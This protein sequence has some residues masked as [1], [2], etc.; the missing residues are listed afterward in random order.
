M[1]DVVFSCVCCGALLNL[2]PSNVYPADT[3]FEAG[4]KGT[5]S[6]TAIDDTKFRQERDKRIFP[7]F[8]TID[9]WGIQRDRIKLLCIS[10]GKL[11]GYIY[12][13]GP[14]I[15]DNPT[16]QY[17]FG[18]SQ[19]VPRL[20]RYRLKIKALHQSRAGAAAQQGK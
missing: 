8:E 1:D 19:V 12:K 10:C 18:P 5:I 14:A 4:N 9:H 11:V 3:Y 6:F 16:G 15:T 2:D 20:P 17:G 13:D 7:F